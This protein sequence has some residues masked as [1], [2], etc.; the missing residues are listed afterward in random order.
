MPLKEM[1]FANH[2]FRPASC[3]WLDAIYTTLSQLSSQ[4]IVLGA[5]FPEV[6][7]RVRLFACH[8]LSNHF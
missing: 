8:K 3:V 4:I 7:L 1:E 2:E 6:D 5:P